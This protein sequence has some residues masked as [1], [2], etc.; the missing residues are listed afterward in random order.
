[1]MRWGGRRK[2]EEEGN[3]IGTEVETDNHVHPTP[4]Q[5]NPFPLSRLF[6]SLPSLYS[7][8]STSTFTSLSFFLP[9]LLSF[10]HFQPYTL[11]FIPP[12]PQPPSTTP[13]FSLFPFIHSPRTIPY[14]SDPFTYTHA[15]DS[16]LLTL[17]SPSLSLH[18]L[19]SLLALTFTYPP[20]SPPYFLP[21][22]LPSHYRPA[23]VNTS[24]IQS[25][26]LSLSLSW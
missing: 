1:M 21:L 9:T 10:S 12:Q 16:L 7:A 3:P 5:A 24:A 17:L 23:G 2:N 18:F 14:P 13:F 4:Q 26:S 25:G 19:S 15:P 20:P 11:P 6:V 22:P 8:S